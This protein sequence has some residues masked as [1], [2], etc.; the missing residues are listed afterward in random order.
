M[1]IEKEGSIPARLTVKDL[2]SF[3][4]L[5]HQR[6]GQLEKEKVIVRGPDS[7]FKADDTLKALM[8]HFRKRKT[9]KEELDK[10]RAEKLKIQ[11]AAMQKEYLPTSEVLRGLAKTHTIVAERLNDMPEA[12]AHSLSPG[13][14]SGAITVLRDYVNQTLDFFKKAI[15]A[16]FKEEN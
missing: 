8:Q 15:E 13:D 16:E 2:Q 6:I 12:L 4:G 10:Y 1:K 11:I 3:T 5:T 7:C 14:P 9:T